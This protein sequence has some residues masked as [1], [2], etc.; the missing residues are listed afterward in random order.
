MTTVTVRGADGSSPSR[1][2]GAAGGGSPPS[3]LPFECR[4]EMLDLLRR[5]ALHVET[6]NVL[7]ARAGRCTSPHIAAVLRERADA[8]R[9]VAEGVLAELLRQGVPA[10]RRRSPDTGRERRGR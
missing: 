7:E 8:R 9:R 6:A 5:Y 2:P 4:R 10:V 3:R 1:G